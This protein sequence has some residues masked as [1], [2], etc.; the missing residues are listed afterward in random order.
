MAL[1]SDVAAADWALG[2]YTDDHVLMAVPELY[3]YGREGKWFGLRQFIVYML[4]G[5]MQVRSLCSVKLHTSL[6]DIL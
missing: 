5:V 3:W 6:S 2:P 1:S 4:D